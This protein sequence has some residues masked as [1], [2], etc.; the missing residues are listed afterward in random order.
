MKSTN[1]PTGTVSTDEDDAWR[2]RQP[3]CR[4]HTTK[5]YCPICN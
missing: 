5:I 1:I 3:Q 4:H 2:E